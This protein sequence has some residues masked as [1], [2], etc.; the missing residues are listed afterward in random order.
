VDVDMP[1]LPLTQ[2]VTVTVQL[3]NDLGQC[4]G[5]EFSAPAFKNEPMEFRDKSD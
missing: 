5:S 3:K 1:P 4:W 2:D